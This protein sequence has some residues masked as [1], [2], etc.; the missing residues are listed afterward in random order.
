MLF[1]LS[2]PADHPFIFN[3]YLKSLKDIRPVQ[4]AVFYKKEHARMKLLLDTGVTVM[5]VEQEDPTHIIGWCN[6][7]VSDCSL[8]FSYVYIKHSF[9]K[10][11]FAK[12]LIDTVLSQFPRADVQYCIYTPAGDSLIN[13][14][15]MEFNPY[16]FD[17]S[18]FTKE[19]K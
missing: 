11:G 7:V 5:L 13:Q 12:D 4:P 19:S 10:N 2:E 18:N 17:V 14:Y 1:R 15:K 9:R 8:I 3:S 16:I 6:A